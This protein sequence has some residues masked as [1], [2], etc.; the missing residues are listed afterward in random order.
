MAKRNTQNQPQVQNSRKYGKR[1]TLKA[2]AKAP[3][4]KRSVRKQAAPVEQIED[5]EEKVSRSIVPAKYRQRYQPHDDRCGDELAER[6]SDAICSPDEKGRMRVD[7][8]KLAK[9]AEANGLDASKWAHL[10]PGHQ[11]MCL[12]N[13][14]RAKARKGESVSW[15]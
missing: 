5:E 12:G 8:A 14:L 13:C 3:A 2:V 4:T 7:E 1:S 6:I 11:R 9:L 10:N 15:V